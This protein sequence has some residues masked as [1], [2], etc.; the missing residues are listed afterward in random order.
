MRMVLAFAVFGGEYIKY[1]LIYIE[2]HDI[3]KQIIKWV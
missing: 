2:K 3:I 1:S